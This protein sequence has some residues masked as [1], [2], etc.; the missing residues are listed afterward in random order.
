MKTKHLS[1][2]I[3]CGL[4]CHTACTTA[5]KVTTWNDQHPQAAANYCAA[6]FPVV[7]ISIISTIH[8]STDTI[9]HIVVVNNINCDSLLVAMPRSV[10]HIYHDT[11]S[12]SVI[13]KYITLQTTATVESTAKLTALRDSTT[14][15]IT[16]LIKANNTAEANCLQTKA[17]LHSWCKWCIIGW[18]IIAIYCIVKYVLPSFTKS[19]I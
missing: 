6:K 9:K 8:D 19:V 16:R 14:T 4:L 7:P 5:R 11:C 10:Q 18:G 15:Q 3:L 1:K 17:H 12:G 13:T 2:L